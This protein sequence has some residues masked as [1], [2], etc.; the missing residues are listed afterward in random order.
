M[1]KIAKLQLSIKI[2]REQLKHAL[3]I[4]DSLYIEQTEKTLSFLKAQLKSYFI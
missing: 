4:G 1:N 3:S 2:T